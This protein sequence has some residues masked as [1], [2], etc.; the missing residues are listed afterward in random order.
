MFGP[1]LEG[2]RVELVLMTI[3]KSLT[4]RWGKAF[5]VTGKLAKY[6]VRV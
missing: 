5:L 3:L 2:E 4:C 1:V 6:E